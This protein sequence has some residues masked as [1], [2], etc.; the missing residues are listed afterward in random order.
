MK[1]LKVL[2][3][4]HKHVELKDLGNLV[5]CNEDLE[6]RLINLKH[7]LDIPEIF[8][9]GTCNRVEF[10]FYGAHELTHEFIAD[11]MGKLN[12]CVPQERLQCYLG[13]VNKYEGMDALNHLLRMSCSL[14]S[15]V[16]GEKEILA[17]VRRAYDRCREAGFTGDFLRLMM[18]RL[19]KTAKEVYTYTK[20]SRNPI[21]VVSLAYRKLRELKLVENPRIIIIGSGETNQN[22]A[23]YFQ[24]N[25][26]AKFVIFNRTLENAKAL[27]EELNAEAYPLADIDQYKEGF[28]ILITCTG[29]P[30]SIIDNTL[31][32]S[33]LNGET[34]KKIIIDLAVPNDVDAE[35]LQNNLI[36]YIEV[37][38]LQAIA[39]KNIQ[40]RY[41]ELES[42]EKIIQDN[43]QEFL[44]L[45]KQRRVE[46]AM[47][48]VP[49]KIKEIKSF[50]LN[51]VF[52]Q[53][54]Q[55]LTPEAREVL[56]KVINY[57]EKKYIKVPMVMAKEILVKTPET[58][59][60]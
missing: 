29:A 21:S 4:T 37:S 5:I 45:I 40:E 44:P 1:N 47:R 33:L 11:F 42:A 57:M 10:V 41:N 53:E 20:I 56:E 55:A 49:E 14:E 3:F 27:A 7:S 24:K 35:V 25:Q 50:A 46:V 15:L 58:E 48:E 38:S 54:V 39:E 60:N 9:I 8:Y 59:K 2:A 52:A 12:F 17:Q 26:K 31:Y 6:S 36:H 18:D 19:V 30:T 34:D 43:I 13:Q 22:L 28:D 32:Q 16:V 51:E 23:K